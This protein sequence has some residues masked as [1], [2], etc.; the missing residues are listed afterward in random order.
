MFFDKSLIELLIL[1]VMRSELLLMN[2]LSFIPF[3]FRD[4]SMFNDLRDS[5]SRIS[6]SFLEDVIFEVL[7]S[8]SF[9]LPHIF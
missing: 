9:S 2:D 4:E 8:W 6:L 5:D 3:S 7:I 1:L